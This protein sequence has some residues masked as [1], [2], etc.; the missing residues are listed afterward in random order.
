MCGPLAIVSRTV[1]GSPGGA[2]GG[3]VGGGNGGNGGDGGRAGKGGGNGQSG[4][5]TCAHR[6][7]YGES[8]S[9]LHAISQ[10]DQRQREGTSQ[11]AIHGGSG[12]QRSNN[13]CR[14]EEAAHRTAPPPPRPTSDQPPKRKMRPL[15]VLQ[16]GAPG[17]RTIANSMSKW[18]VCSYRSSNARRR[19][20]GFSEIGSIGLSAPVPLS[21]AQYPVSYPRANAC[22]WRLG[23]SCSILLVALSSG[24]RASLAASSAPLLEP[25]RKS[26][27]LRVESS[28]VS[29]CANS[30]VIMHSR[31]SLG[32]ACPVRKTR[33][34]H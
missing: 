33:T 32:G 5:N 7:M 11:R 8:S 28:V 17:V 29:A 24:P 14:A 31:T 16:H 30:L 34:H 3:V 19:L 20:S 9:V 23:D 22:A 2:A 21:L 26:T 13:D 4:S 15:L 18:S 25:L 10:R 1:A 27:G 12:Q 6:E